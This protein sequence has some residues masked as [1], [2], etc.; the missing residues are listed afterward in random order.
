MHS[1]D[2]ADGSLFDRQARIEINVPDSATFSSDHVHLTGTALSAPLSTSP[3]FASSVTFVIR[4]RVPVLP[5]NRGW[6]MSQIP[7]YGWSRALAIQDW[8]FGYVG[9]TPGYFDSTL[10][11]L[12]AG[13]WA[14][15]VGIW[16]QNRDCQTWLNGIGGEIQSSCISGSGDD[17]ESIVIGGRP[18]ND[19][20]HN[21][22]TIDISHAL[23]YNRSI[24]DAE[25]LQI[26][27]ALTPPTP[28]SIIFLF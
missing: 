7:D 10:G 17:V 13:S 1:S 27:N 8:R 12:S 22:T 25:V 24:T 20:G 21:P 18:G 4:L 28:G 9:Q 19:T 15:L 14:V 16:T 3:N 23:V 11:Q 2:Y 26:T 5:T 6:V